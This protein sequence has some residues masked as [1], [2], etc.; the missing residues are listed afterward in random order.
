MTF[1]DQEQD[2]K[3]NDKAEGQGN[4]GAL[5]KAGR[6]IA[7]ERDGSG[8]QSVGKLGGHMIDV[9]ALGAGGGHN[10]GV[11]DR[12]QWSPQTAPAMQAEMAIIII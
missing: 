7:H 11:R 12:E 4:Q 6:D 3:Q 1:P 10:G 5:C 2:Q 9:A 8:H